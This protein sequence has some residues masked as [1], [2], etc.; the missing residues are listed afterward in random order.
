MKVTKR[1]GQLEDVKFDKVTR[2]LN[3][4]CQ[5]LTDVQ[6]SDITREVVQNMY[7]NIP[8]SQV[9]EL[10][11]DTCM[12]R[13]WKEPQY[14]TLAIRLL[15]DNMRKMAPKSFWIA[16]KK[17]WDNGL[18]NDDLF[19]W[20]KDNKDDL[21]ATIQ[22]ERDQ[23]LTFFGIKTLIK[24][25]LLSVDGVLL[26]TPQFM[27]LRVACAVHYPNMEDVQKAYEYMSKGYYTHATPTLFNAGSKRQQC[28]SCYLMGIHNDSLTD[29][30]K[31]LDQC[32]QVSK[33]AGGVGMHVSH[34]RAK[35]SKIR[36]TNG[37][38][39]GIIP[40]LR[41]FNNTARYVNQG[42]KRKGSVAVYLEPW[43]AD[44]VEFLELRLNEG[45]PEARCRDL[46]TALW[47]PDLF[48]ERLQ[49]NGDWSLFCPDECPGLVDTWGEEFNELYRRYES[50][51][52]ARRT[53]PAHKLWTMVIKSQVE[54][55]TPYILYKDTCNRQS[56]Q[57]NLGTIKCSNLCC[58]IVQNTKE[59][60]I[61]VCNLASIALPKFVRQGKVM[62]DEL[63]EVARFVTRSLDRV[64]DRNFYPTP[65]AQRS[66][67]RHR[68]IGIGVQGLADVFHDAGVAFDSPGAQDI[69][70]N[71]FE[72]IYFGAV[73]E[74]NALGELLGNYDS[75]EGSPIHSGQFQ[76]DMSTQPTPER[77]WDWEELRPKVARNM[78]NSL[79]LAP[80]PTASTAQI[81]GNNECF[82]PYTSNLY[83]RRT[84]AGEFVMVNKH[85]VKLL[86]SKDQ[87]TQETRD[88]LMASQGS[89][90]DMGDILSPDEMN[91]FKTAWELSMRT[92]IDMASDRQQFICQSQSMNL[93]MADPTNAKISSMLMYAWKKGLKT[94]MYYLRTRPKA[95]AQQFTL[96]PTK[97]GNTNCESCSA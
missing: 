43:H 48:M 9:D 97:F 25:Y 69:N 92:V 20:M 62:Y 66:N 63:V 53:M 1:N 12:A 28:S 89:V 84:M 4:L 50:E 13:A 35:G 90:Q 52:K 42:G 80:M 85:L 61:A 78:R 75:F 59:D 17:C 33:W 16:V 40:M 73:T 23:D 5:D 54:T 87:W 24:S 68:P 39:D 14:E 56:N 2:R 94:G 47:M 6:P 29:I 21:N 83:L 27:W 60:E 44:V 77:M 11:A 30:Y 32:A 46:F 22:A 81:L 41:V 71:I 49:T 10:S 95:K 64:I 26:E 74:S 7:D 57:K 19:K 91:Q 88:R 96:D 79:L 72:S 38:S 34:I 86:K 37:Q 15:C 45:D 8:T 31:V 51:G 55:G 76:W 3:A 58:E 82:E 65:E 67:M 36:G 18:I 70:K 93:F